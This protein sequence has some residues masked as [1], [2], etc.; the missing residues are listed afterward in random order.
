MMHMGMSGRY[1]LQVRDAE[2]HAVVKDSGWF[3]NLIL[4]SGLEALGTAAGHVLQYCRVG[5]GNTAPAVTQTALVNQ[6]ASTATKA[7][8]DTVGAATS[9]PYY[10]WTRLVFRFAAGVATG[11][12]AEIGI[13]WAT[14]GNT[15][16]SRSLVKDAGGNP[17][18]ITVLASEYLD[19]T[20]E[21]RVYP[22]TTVST[23]TVTIG[24]VSTTVEHS[25]R[26][27]TTGSSLDW[28]GFAQGQ[29][30]PASTYANAP[31][32][33]GTVTDAGTGNFYS[34]VATVTPAAY[35]SGTRQ[36][37]VTATIAP[38]SANSGPI[39]AVRG[40]LLGVQ[41]KTRFQPAIA[42]DNTKQLTFTYQ[43][44][45]GRREV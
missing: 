33:L 8:S 25:C 14:T 41:T 29:Y 23:Q 3:S 37:Q 40:T 9:A 42:K 36:R 15:L 22:D 28:G 10:W 31:T 20:Y 7:V 16:F 30:T 21:I 5:T 2:T 17:T 24:G 26:N 4:D 13:G 32:T 6:L 18:T 35:S 19:V 38:G 27:V 44:S 39:E 12:V 43:V 11:N 34:T 1:R 45:W